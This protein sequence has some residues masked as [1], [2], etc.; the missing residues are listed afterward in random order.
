MHTIPSK[1]KRNESLT[2][3]G[4]INPCPVEGVCETL[5]LRILSKD[6]V[7]DWASHVSNQLSSDL[8]GAGDPKT[9]RVVC[10]G[11]QQKTVGVR[12]ECGGC[13]VGGR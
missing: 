3:G 8:L 5:S 11:L 13:A 1:R 7:S 6:A 4:V 12:W 10:H 9:T 2:W